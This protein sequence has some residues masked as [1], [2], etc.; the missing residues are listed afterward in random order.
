M[1]SMPN[2]AFISLALCL[3]RFLGRLTTYPQGIDCINV[4]RFRVLLLRLQ[5]IECDSHSELLML[6]GWLHSDLVDRKIVVHY[7]YQPS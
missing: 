6:S 1:I 7:L 3:T 5:G 2:H 4:D